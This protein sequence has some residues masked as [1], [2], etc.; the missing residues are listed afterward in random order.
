M[1]SSNNAIYTKPI[2]Q[3][4]IDTVTI[5]PLYKNWLETLADWK[6]SDVIADYRAVPYDWRLTLEDVLKT[7]EV[8]GKI[9][10]DINTSY[11]DSYIYQSLSA[12]VQTSK[13]NK[14]TIVAHS[15]GGLVA[16]V[17]IMAMQA[18]NDVLLDS[19]DTLILV[20]VPQTG[21]PDAITSI[22]HGSELGYG[23]ISDKKTS[24]ALTNT[25]PFAH[26]LL[27][28]NE[29]LEGS[30]ASVTSALIDFLPGSITDS[31]RSQFGESINSIAELHGF[32]SKDSGR[33]KPAFADVLTPEVV[34]PFLLG[35]ANTVHQGLSQFSPPGSM[36]ILQLGGIGVETIESITYFTDRECLARSIFS[37]FQ[38]TEY[39]DKLGYRINKV[40]EGDGTVVLPSALAMSESDNNQ[41][42]WIN[43]EEYNKRNINRVHRNILEITEL[44]DYI[45]EKISSSTPAGYQYISTE[46]I[47]LTESSRLVFQLHSPLDLKVISED[48]E[49]SSTTNTIRGGTYQRVGELQYISIPDDTNNPQLQLIGYAEGSFTLDVEEWTG[50]ELVERITF[51]GL[52][53]TIGTKAQ[54][55]L[56]K[57]LAS[58]TLALDLTGDG[59]SEA[60]AYSNN[61]VII[62]GE[63]IIPPIVNEKEHGSS[64]GGTRLNRSLNG[65]VAGVSSSI[66]EAHILQLRRIV[67]IL[68]QILLLLKNYYE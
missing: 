62:N 17:L 55:Q 11:Q 63:V 42:V 51:S 47:V 45:Q 52:P 36:E 40:P 54:L 9:V 6:Q 13:S 60:T 34:D 4:V 48:G 38:C 59:T 14:V 10:Y 44:Q 12:L 43:L 41:R 7:K 3:A 18:N 26:H 32:L 15:N 46:P 39:R 2:N 25:A 67:E 33:V 24:R 8:N 21:T 20:A 64:G 57:V 66:S 68:Q 27:P 31:W 1:G 49:V 35:Y 50:T 28:S 29:Y 65:Q 5:L 30:G 58:S 19:I 56:D 53:T 61:Q 22:L 37:F 23:I 16:K